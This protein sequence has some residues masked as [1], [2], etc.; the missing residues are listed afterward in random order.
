MSFSS[1]FGLSIQSGIASATF[2]QTLKNIYVIN[3]GKNNSFKTAAVQNA[4]WVNNSLGLIV[5]DSQNTIYNISEADNSSQATFFNTIGIATEEETI[6]SAPAN[7]NSSVSSVDS[8]IVQQLK[9]IEIP[10]IVRYKIIDKRL[11]V[12]I[13]GG[14]STNILIGTNAL[15]K[16]GNSTTKFG[17][18]IGLKPYNY[19]GSAGFGIS[20]ALTSKIS[21]LFEPT[22]K[23]YLNYISENNGYY[24]HPYSY[25]MFTGIKYQF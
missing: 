20:Y 17:K 5:D 12:N 25:A 8:K 23:Y 24:F 10:I 21:F 18:T 1:W 22:F 19:I 6:L 11:D 15:F 3:Q 13:L 4:S 7:S 16:E 2:G 9:V 14:L